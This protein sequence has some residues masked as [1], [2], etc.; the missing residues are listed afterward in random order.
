MDA[1]E[2]DLT[3][4]PGLEAQKAHINPNFM[5][6]GSR[7]LLGYPLLIAS[8]VWDGQREASPDKRVF[9]L[10]RSGYLGLQRYGAASWSGDITSTWTAMRKQITAGLG[11]SISGLPYWTMDIGGFSVPERFSIDA[12]GGPQTSEW[13][14]LNTR[15]FQ[16]GTFVPL[17][18][19]HGQVPRR[20]MWFFGNQGEPA[21]DTMLNFDRLR[22][23][24]L[25]YIYS[26]AG[27][28][29]QDG[30]TL[31]R[32]LVMDFPGDALARSLTDQYNFG[33]ALMVSPV[34]TYRARTRPVFLPPTAG[35][36][37]DFWTG[38]ALG[39]GKTIEADAPF[40]RIP[41]MVRAGS[42]IPLGPELQ[43][44]AEKPSDPITLLLY[45]G[46]DATFSLY[47]D[48]GLSNGY[49]KGVFARI[50]I[51]WNEATRTLS[52]GAREGHFEGMLIQHHFRIVL[53]APDKP[54]PF[55]FE[56]RAD[57]ELNYDGSPV[58][59]RL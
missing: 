35:G 18:R 10:T 27:A 11:Y 25:P 49:E 17:L 24:L 28:A 32:P 1:S 50:P 36:W 34:T 54:V 59:Q 9:N 30:G 4:R 22:Y 26:L 38:A 42:I 31:M 8:A 19:V 58:Q 7:M 33:P 40:E 45:T 6:T 15:W 57:V 44:A 13:R 21:Y 3:S 12:K 16:F 23:R 39:S 51:M 2:P 55:S 47:E 14:E 20:E 48:D 43:Y 29:T 53:I 46:K 52:I 5:G 56:P 41:L 37:Y